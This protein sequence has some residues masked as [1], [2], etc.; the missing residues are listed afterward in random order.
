[1]GLPE[2]YQE[3]IERLCSWFFTVGAR[4]YAICVEKLLEIIEKGYTTYKRGGSTLEW[5]VLNK[6]KKHGILRLTR[7]HFCG[8]LTEKAVYVANRAGLARLRT[9]LEML[10]RAPPACLESNEG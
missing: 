3:S 9:V 1:M 5:Y 8:E 10:D 4:T 6:L 7:I 2:P